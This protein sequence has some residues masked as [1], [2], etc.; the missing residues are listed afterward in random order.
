V[1]LM[2]LRTLRG[3]LSLLERRLEEQQKKYL[4][5]LENRAV[6]SDDVLPQ[7][8]QAKEEYELLLG[9]R[10]RIQASMELALESRQN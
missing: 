7:L 10:G 9:E 8:R 2:S 6:P 4:S 3:S 1:L 5:L